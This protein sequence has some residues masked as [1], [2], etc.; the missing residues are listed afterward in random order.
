MG[1]N[2]DTWK[3]KE[4][5]DFTLPLDKLKAYH[6]GVETQASEK[7]DGIWISGGELCEIEGTLTEGVVHV[8]SLDMGGEGSGWFY[9]H[10]VANVFPYSTGRLVAAVV[11]EGGDSINRLW[12]MDG[13]VKSERIEL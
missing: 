1:Y 10:L 5:V 2:I 12:V 3:T 13:T 7:T 8:E 11:W 4:M 6:H 9:H